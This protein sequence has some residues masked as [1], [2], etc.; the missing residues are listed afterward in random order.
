MNFAQVANYTFTQTADTYTPIT[1]GTV[2]FSGSFDENISAAIPIPTFNFDGVDRTSL[3]VS[4]N[5][6][7][8]FGTAPTGTNYTPIS[9]TATYTGAISPFARDLNNGA[10][11]TPEI[12][13]EQ[14]GNEFVVQWQDVRRYNIAGELLSFQVRLNSSNNSIKIVYGGT[15]TPGVST[16]YPQ[17][18]LRGPNN[19]FATNVKNRTIAVSGGN[20]INSLPGTLN[21]STMY[22]NSADLT[23]V[24]SVGLTYTFTPPN[25]P[26]SIAYT[27]LLNTSSTSNRNLSG[28]LITDPDGV[29]GTAGTAP[30]IYFKKSTD[31]NVFGGN[32]S[33]DNGW[34]WT[35]STG[36]SPFNFT[37]DYSIINGGAVTVADTIQY[38]VVA[39]DLA[40]TPAV[41]S[42]PSAGFAGTSVSTI[43][44][45]PTVPNRYVISPTAL[46][47]S[48]TVG[49]T[50]FNKLTGNNVSFNKTVNKVVKEVWVENQSSEKKD[51]SSEASILPDGKYEFREIE[52]VSYLPVQDGMPYAGDLYFKKID[53]PEFNFP[54]GIEGV[55][56]TITAAVADLNLRGV[57]GPTTFLLVDTLYSSE[58]LPI[59]VNVANI[60]LPTSTNTI[61]IKPNAG[62]SALISGTSASAQVIK[63]LSSYVT[64]DGSNS[65]GTSRNLTIQ[66]LSATSP[67]VM[68]IGSS[69]TTF[70]TNVAIKNCNLINGINTSSA[71]VVSDGITAGNPGWFKNIT[72]QNNS[73]QKAYIGAYCNAVVSSGNGSGLL[74][75]Q[76]NLNTSGT[77]AV[78]FVGIYLQG[79]DSTTVSQNSIANF[80]GVTGEDDRGIWLATGTRNTI[81]ERNTISTLKYTGTG[82]YGAHGLTISTGTLNANITIKNNMISD[83]SGDAWG[84]SIL[85]DNPFG[86]YVFSVQTGIKIY[87]NS[88]NLFG[89]TLNRAN[90][91]SA[92]I[93]LGT[94]STADIKNNI[95][96][97]DLGALTT[98]GLSSIGV[99]LQTDS[100]QLVASDF[101]DIYVN[102]SGTISKFIGQIAA[103]GQT[104]LVGWQNATGTDLNSISDSVAFTS[105]TDL[106][107]PNGTITALESAGTPIVGI[108][109][110]IDGQTRNASTP[111]IG[112]DEFNGINPADVLA[113]DYYIPQGVNPQGFN[114]LVDAFA[115]LNSFG[116]SSAV[117]FLIDDNLN[118]VGANLLITR[119]DLTE[120][121][122]LIIKPAPTKT[123]TITITGCVTTAGAT[124]YSGIAY[125]GASYITI[126]GSNTVGGTTRDLTIAMND[127]LN[128]RI[129]ITLYGNTDYL[130]FKNFYLKFNLINLPNTSTRGMYANGQASGVA[131]SVIIENCQ[132]GD[133]NHAGAYAISITG[134]SGSL[135]YA[136]RIHIINNDL[137]GTLRP[138]YFFYGGA[139]GT[140]SEITGNIIQSPYAPPS[141][142]VVWGILFNT[143]NGTYN[144]HGNKLQKLISASSATNG[145]YGIGTLTSQPGVQMNI[146]N[147][148]LGGDFQ[149]SGT[150]IPASV[151]VISFQDNIP[152]ANVYYNTIVL[153]NINKPTAPR[154]TGIRWGGT[155]NVNIKN[156]IVINEN[157]AATA[158]VFYNA[159]G[160]FT[161]D[162]NDL[163]VS[164]TLANIG[165]SLTQVLKTFS[166]WQDTTSQDANSI[167]VAAP[168]TSALDFHIPDGTLTPIESGGTPIALITTDIDGQPRNASTPDIGADEFLGLLQINAPSNLTAVADTFAVLLNWADNSTNETG[169]YIERKN[170]DS[171]SVDPYAVIDT[172]GTDVVSYN[173]TGRTPNTTYTYRIQ[174]FNLLGVSQYSNEVTTTTIIPVELTSFAVNVSDKVISI[175]WST[176][177]ELNNRG[178][179]LERKLDGTW[180]KVTFIEGKGTTTKKSDYSYLDKFR[181]EGFQGTVQY[182]LKQID[183][184]GTITYSN[185]IS[186]DVD[187]TPKEYTLYQNYPNPFNPSTTIKFALPFDS[188]VRITIYNMLGEQMD[189]IFD[190]V[191]EVGYHNVSWNARDL[192]SGVYIY[193]IDAKSL[194]GLKNFNSVK[195]MMLVK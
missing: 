86:I 161:S 69:G 27:V 182:R 58:T 144:I 61:T 20:W 7:L 158:Y 25:F 32:T 30:R 18:G 194:D 188:N 116:V 21:S 53:H 31:A 128:G 179:D 136:S 79:V 101:N 22:F 5:G 76:N 37:I 120:T 150:G 130:V 2:L 63:I 131:D 121:N 40:G 145:V 122:N 141:G 83:I 56:A 143:F 129:G 148:F 41:G 177:T 87:Y 47:G 176:A 123:P 81:V 57:S 172:V 46:T 169:F 184:D 164:G 157:D 187:F 65:G 147:N 92:G 171:L 66:N 151:D 190:Q 142:N 186:V 156:N 23:T 127:S 88:I 3:Y 165:Y 162:Y 138:V 115:A 124:Q 174:A 103:N 45:A 193:A 71:L 60:N 137:Y 113:G 17:V 160:T 74:L 64:I 72:I 38:F 133:Q 168:F 35:E 80:D 43:V 11:G 95:V 8:T 78:R 49:L 54:D 85:G 126:D 192:A 29:N 67:Q 178:F 62:V 70:I 135:L 26:P 84:T 14:V 154:L 91:I 155:A 15:I 94:G 185:V 175:V 119:S 48:Y 109:T 153:N 4:A 183:F 89:N 75:T 180:E 82:G 102:P 39:Q 16:S 68:L 118:E 159:S 112:A 93:V 1:G 117:R 28:V 100:T 191:K 73:I 99:Y 110:D 42:N 98:L 104:T 90:A 51:G 44:S 125:S 106:H 12:R 108:T 9:S 33:G 152:Q 132:I 140:T 50:L 114:T 111:D 139:A 10:S 189:V 173:D 77:N 107:I 59:S 34:K 55:Y 13:Y 146:Y 96:V 163:Y 6:F 134:S 105:S 36:T 97:N 19:T 149:H 195:K 52:E 181:Y 24:P 167:N 166:A 170:G